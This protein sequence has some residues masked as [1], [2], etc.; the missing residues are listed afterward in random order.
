MIIKN[1]NVQTL[2]QFQ[3]T[4]DSI[5]HSSQISYD[6]RRQKSSH[7]FLVYTF[8]NQKSFDDAYSLLT[9]V[10]FEQ[11]R[12]EF[13]YK[14]I[15]LQIMR[16]TP[17]LHFRGQIIDREAAQKYI[18]SIRCRRREIF[19]DRI[20]FEFENILETLFVLNFLINRIKELYSLG[21]CSQNRVEGSI[22]VFS[23]T[24]I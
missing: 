8:S 2:N 11:L 18:A 6:T 12:K 7:K 23:N 20:V 14:T 5:L 21:I 19:A 3:K 4:V 13:G 1:Y 16:V 10:Y 15:D 24:Y 22:L 17:Y 9:L